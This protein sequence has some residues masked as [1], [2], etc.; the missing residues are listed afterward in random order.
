MSNAQLSRIA[1]GQSK[2]SPSLARKLEDVTGGGL[3]AAALLDLPGTSSCPLR[4]R[5]DGKW[6]GVVGEEGLR[7]GGDA[8]AAL[9]F[10]PG[11]TVIVESVQ[12]GL[13]IT[14][15]TRTVARAQ[16][17]LRARVPEGYSVVDELLAERRAEAE[18]E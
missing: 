15:V 7:L 11:E 4:R 9:G 12:D 6:V 2:P 5:L 14:S 3:S 16:A 18:R 10:Q 13:T 1:S 8:L 17:E